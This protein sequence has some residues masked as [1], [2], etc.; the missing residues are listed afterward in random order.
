MK[1]I[2]SFLFLFII[3]FSYCQ[4]SIK[5]YY[6]FWE[7]DI[8]K[9]LNNAVIEDKLEKGNDFSDTFLEMMKSLTSEIKE[10]SFVQY[11]GQRTQELKYISTKTKGENSC[12]I[13]IDIPADALP[14]G[15][16]ATLTF[17]SKN[18]LENMKMESS[19]SNDMNFYIWKKKK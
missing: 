5:D 14:E 7:V 10:G 18:K 13:Y 4:N 16:E 3:T 9:T 11:M 15:K 8:E 2:S 19:L 12:I 1:L 6:G 17:S